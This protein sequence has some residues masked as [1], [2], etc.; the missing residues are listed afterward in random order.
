MHLS[1]DLFSATHSYLALPM[2]RSWG[3]KGRFMFKA[4]GCSYPWCAHCIHCSSP[5]NGKVGAITPPWPLTPEARLLE[6]PWSTAAIWQRDRDNYQIFLVFTEMTNTPF[7]EA[8]LHSI[9]WICLLPP[10]NLGRCFILN[11]SSCS[12]HSQRSEVTHFPDVQ[13]FLIEK[14]GTWG[15]SI[16]PSKFSQIL[17]TN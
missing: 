5:S 7:Y 17:Y 8:L 13:S 3:C 4:V 14:I 16:L 15:E 11:F 1:W 10:L 2:S 12:P 9:S 6:R